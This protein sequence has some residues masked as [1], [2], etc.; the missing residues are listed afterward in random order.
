LVADQSQRRLSALLA[1]DV[2]G[3]S[4]LM[5]LDE[6]ETVRRVTAYREQVEVL[7][8]QGRGRLAD[9]TGDAFLAEFPSALD[10]VSAALEIQRVVGARNASVP[11]ERRIEFRIG[12]HLGDVRVEGERLFGDSVNIAARLQELAP[13]G[14][15]CLSAAVHEQVRGKLA[16]DCQDLGPCALKNIPEPVRAQR[17]SL[18]FERRAEAPPPLPEQPSIAV[19]PFA[20]LSGDPDQEYFADGMT[21]DLI[22]DLAKLSGLLVIARNSAFVY[23]G[24]AVRVQ[25]VGREL[26][27]RH[28]LEG[29]V[30]KAGSRVRITA[31]LIEAASGHHLWAERYDGELADIFALQDEVTRK[32][33]E[34]LRVRLRPGERAAR[35]R[36]PTRNP[37]AYDCLLRGRALSRM[38]TREAARR[39]LEL[40]ERATQLDPAFALAWAELGQTRMNA[41]VL[42]YFEEGDRERA[43]EATRR[44][45]ELDPAE[46]LVHAVLANVLSMR[47]SHDEA[48]A[49]AR[50]AIAIDPGSARC[51]TVLGT[52]LNFDDQPEEALRA[53]DWARRLDPQGTEWWC[54]FQT[55]VAYRMLGRWEPAIAAY[56][57]AL[58]TSPEFPPGYMSIAACY[59]HLGDVERAREALVELQ[60]LDPDFSLARLPRL[61]FRNPKALEAIAEGLRKAGMR[62]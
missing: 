29:S 16:L 10:A 53:L 11:P 51:W 54:E 36:A 31:Q 59:G 4:R 37:D 35:E 40:F 44:A 21:D 60:R 43:F 57:R 47:G 6:D 14:G 33:V 7:V 25:D 61:A 15:L 49:S 39:A 3:Y 46:G 19:L 24:R 18:A 45:V 50:R 48:V 20:N 42:R 38:R 34:A 17:V 41:W 8:R 23:K 13:P 56:R 52:V 62:D 2:A 55:G 12:A 27:V 28:V 30:R 1:A 9:F 32:I 22:T 5:A 26:G 58:A